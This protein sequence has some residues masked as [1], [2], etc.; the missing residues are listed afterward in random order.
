MSIYKDTDIQP[1]YYY[2]L[3]K[4][5]DLYCY[6]ELSRIILLNGKNTGGMGVEEIPET[7]DQTLDV[8]SV[9]RTLI[10]VAVRPEYA[11]GP[12]EVL[13]IFC[14]ARAVARGE[15]V[16]T[17]LRRLDYVYPYHQTIGFYMHRAGF[18]RA[19]LAELKA[20][21]ITYDFY[22]CHGLK[23]PYMIQ[24]GIFLCRPASTESKEIS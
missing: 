23:T 15:S 16:L 21:G 11:G 18:D 19:F 20:M 2:R 7:D 12:S 9:E 4:I 8:T 14:R 22:L 13:Q 24:S 6:I 5:A 1:L 10:D 17:M 3:T